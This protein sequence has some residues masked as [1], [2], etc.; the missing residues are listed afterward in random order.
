MSIRPVRN[1]HDIG[2]V[3]E[4]NRAHDSD[5][6]YGN[7]WDLDDSR[8]RPLGPK[9]SLDRATPGA[10]AHHQVE[11]VAV[12]VFIICNDFG[13]AS[14]LVDAADQKSPVMAHRPLYL[15]AGTER[16]N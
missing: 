15:G 11:S 12:R 6:G 2:A 9:F 3:P 14:V 16:C 5:C 7:A 1:C 8:T 10:M 13:Q 4:G